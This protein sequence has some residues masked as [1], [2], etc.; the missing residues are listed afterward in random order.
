M[1]QIKIS[2]LQHIMKL[3]VGHGRATI[4]LKLPTMLWTGWPEDIM[5]L[6]DAITVRSAHTFKE[7]ETRSV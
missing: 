1:K 7:N 4:P 6:R 5:R 2:Y 3:V